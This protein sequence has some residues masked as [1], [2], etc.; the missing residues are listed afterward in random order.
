LLDATLQDLGWDDAWAS[1]LEQLNEDDLIPGRV[2]EQHRGEYVVWTDAGEVRAKVAGR[3]RYERSVG[4]ELPSV[5][6]WVPLVTCP[7]WRSPLD[8]G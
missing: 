7:V 4:G 1:E 8:T 3:L 5:G 6:D 2:A